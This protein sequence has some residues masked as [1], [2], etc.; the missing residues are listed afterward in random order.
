MTRPILITGLPR[1]GTSWV[2]K[3]LQASGEVVY[4]N[5]PLNPHRPPGRSPGVLNASVTNAF[6]YICEDNETPWLQAFQDTSALRY[7]VVAELRANRSVTDLARMGK[8]LKAF[9]L[10]RTRGRRALFD[11]PYAILSVA[12]FAERLGAITVVLVRD[13]VTWAGSWRKLGWTTYF[14][15]LLE[16]PL[17][18]RD[19]LGQHTDELRRLVGSQDELEKNAALWRIT[20]DA[21]DG[22]RKRA[23]LHVVRY[24]DLASEPEKAFGELYRTCELEWD[25]EAQQAIQAATQADGEPTKAMSWSL[26]GGLS[27]TAYQAMDSKS[28]LSTFKDR[29]TPEE[30]AR[31]TE[32]TAEVKS[33]FY[34]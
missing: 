20:Y 14:H 6:Q 7:H 31:V 25:S 8:N 18:M 29:L 11:D 4:V 23:D 2:G 27:R 22:L 28:A 33:R 3:M 13:P 26:K 15:E 24:E 30:I 5:E 16:Q 19:L 12:W 9:T 32:L 21:I 1:S 17:L 10:G 34:D